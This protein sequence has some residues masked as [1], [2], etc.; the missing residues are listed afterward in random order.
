MIKWFD[1]WKSY[2]HV[3]IGIISVFLPFIAPI[4]FSYELIELIIGKDDPESFLGDLAEF[5]CRLPN[6]ISYNL[7]I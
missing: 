6:R 3:I 4:Y 1:D 7:H 5:F 2:F